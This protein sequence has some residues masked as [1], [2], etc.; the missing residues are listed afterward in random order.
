VA[1]QDDLAGGA[2]FGGLVRLDKADARGDLVGVAVQRAEAPALVGG[3]EDY[4][5][6]GPLGG[7]EA[8]DDVGDV[9]G[10][11]EAVAEPAEEEDGVW[12]GGGGGRGEFEGGEG[13]GLEGG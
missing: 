2:E 1:E 10:G 8:G 11:G 4:R 13:F 3:G 6:E 7:G 9:G 12:L 5:E